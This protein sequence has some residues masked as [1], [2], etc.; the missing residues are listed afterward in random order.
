MNDR[1]GILE[2][3]GD[4]SKW[5][6]IEFRK[7]HELPS[8]YE[9]IEVLLTNGNIQKGMI[10][11]DE[12]DDFYWCNKSDNQLISDELVKAWRYFDK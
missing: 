7:N 2:K 8:A 10:V 11:R 9:E 3:S 4:D 6:I 12:C 1:I 5:K